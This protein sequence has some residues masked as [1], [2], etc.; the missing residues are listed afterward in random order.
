MKKQKMERERD[1]DV[2]EKIALGIHKGTGVSGG[3]GM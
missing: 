3:D 2:S 1:R